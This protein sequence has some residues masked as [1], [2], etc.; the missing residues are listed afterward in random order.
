M[1]Q[2]DEHRSSDAVLGIGHRL[3]GTR[4][5]RFVLLILG[6]LVAWFIDRKPVYD[7]ELS[8]RGD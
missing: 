2:R 8:S 3:D 4:G 7:L 5:Y 1:K 6:L